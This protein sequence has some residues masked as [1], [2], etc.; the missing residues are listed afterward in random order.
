MSDPPAAPGPRPAPPRLEQP[1]PSLGEACALFLIIFV[2]FAAVQALRPYAPILRASAA[3]VIVFLLPPITYAFLYGH[4][5]R[6]TFRLAPLRPVFVPLALAMALAS[7]LVLCQASYWLQHWLPADRRNFE[8]VERNVL[9]ILHT[10]WLPSLV[11]IALLPALSEELLFRGFLLSALLVPAGRLGAVI[12]TSVLFG[13]LHGLPAQ[14]AAMILLGLLY[15][16]CALRCG[17]IWFSLIAHATNNSLVIICLKTPMFHDV[18]WLQAQE[19]V[20]AVPLVCSL[21]ILAAG[22]FVLGD[23]PARARTPAPERT[24]TATPI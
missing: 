22:L 11:V 18:P 19:P 6:L 2:L 23:A 20:P 9:E 17:S 7:F 1:L 5:L 16:A 10:G 14:Q 12:V 24:G 21:L 8:E 3:S 15:G 13:L 4:N